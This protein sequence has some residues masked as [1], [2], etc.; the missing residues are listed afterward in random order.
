ML[1][2]I[3]ASRA[4]TDT[5]TGTETFSRELIRALVGFDHGNTYRLYT[6]DAVAPSF[7][8][9]SAE[10]EIRAIPFPRLW[11]H[12][13]LSLEMQSRPPDVLFVPAH[14][15][16]LVH[17]RR[18]LVT[19]HDLGHCV[20][21]RAHPL[22]QR[23]YHYWSTWW[24]CRSAMHLFA[25]SQA[26]RDDMVRFY[27]VAPE[28]VTVV[29]PAYHAALFKPVRDLARI[30]EAKGR[31][32]IGRDYILAIGTIHPRKNYERLIKA[33]ARLISD[34]Q[35]GEL[36]LVIVGKKGWL[37]KGILD[38]VR[39]L[40][41]DGCVRFLDYAPPDD[42]PALLSGARLFAFPSLHEGFG[43][44]IL[45]AQACG[46]PVVCSMTSSLPEV[47]GDGAVFVDPCDA[48]AISA[49]MARLMTDELLREK[50]V[51][52]G[53]ENVKRFSWEKSAR[54]VL[55]VIESVG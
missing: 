29:Y 41:L 52:H 50:V 21:P 26:T 3:D 32:G 17:P 14:V 25:D 1:I 27:S 28:K 8:S 5:P 10:P 23:M 4:V 44:P 39:E 31:S 22:R 46:T 42:M 33:F 2:G 37:F 20:F 55:D 49:A 48:D 45:E 7:F 35:H 38:K 54:E 30:R 34:P 12:L 16:P 6:R 18:T 13:R 47:A 19:V 53:L 51:A 40:G 15:L 36:D 43:I 24:N 11:T 9:E